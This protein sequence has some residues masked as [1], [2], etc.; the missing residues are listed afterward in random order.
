MKTTQARSW[1]AGVI[2]LIAIGGVAAIAVRPS[3]AGGPSDDTQAQSGKAGIRAYIDPQTG[4]LGVPPPGTALPPSVEAAGR[5][6]ANLVEVPS[7][8]SAGGVMVN[9]N[10]RVAADVTATIDLSGK[11][12]V[13]CDPHGPDH[14]SGPGCSAP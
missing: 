13:R 5:R 8:G 4:E 9:T 10:G 1:S 7:M 14:S 11:T 6:T 3:M 2:G 12:A